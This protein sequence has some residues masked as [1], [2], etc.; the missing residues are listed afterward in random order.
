MIDLAKDTKTRFALTIWYEGVDNR[1]RPA[2]AEISFA[3]DTDEG[4]VS[5]AAALRGRELLL[6]MQ[7]LDWADP[8]Q[9]TKT[10]LAGCAAEPLGR[11]GV[12]GHRHGLPSRHC[13]VPPWRRR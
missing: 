6:A 9:P 10:T 11:H 4:A 13:Q 5:A 8:G 3:H 1:D 7:D 12:F 2:L